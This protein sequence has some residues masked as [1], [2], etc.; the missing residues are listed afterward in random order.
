MARNLQSYFLIAAAIVLSGCAVGPNYKRP[1][2]PAS[3]TFKEPPPPG[4]KQAQ[5][6]AAIPR[7]KWWEIYND[8]QLNA[9][10]E[11]VAINNQNV[12]AAAARYREARDQVRIARSAYFPTIT[13]SPG[14]SASH[15]SDTLRRSNVSNLVNGTVVDYTLPVNFSYQADLWGSIRRS[16]RANRELAQASAADLENAKLSFQAQL[17]EFYFEL[18]GLDAEAQLL[19]TTVKIFQ[20]FLQLTKDRVEAGIASGADVAQAQTQLETTRAQL[21]DIGVQRASFEHALA[22]LIGKPPAELTLAFA[23]LQSV[24]PP[25]P[26]GVPSALLERRPDIASAERQVAAAN[27]QIGIAMA[28]YFPNLTL[29]AQGGLES[30]SFGQWLTWPSRFWSAGP[31]LAEV[32]FNGGK[33]SA[34]IDQQRA[35]YD[36]TAANY[37]QTVLTAFQQVEDNLAALRILEQEAAAQQQAVSAAEES[38]RIITEQYKAGTTDYL[39]VITTQS[40]ALQNERTALQIATRRMTASALLVE[41]LG[42]GWDSSQLPH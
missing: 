20:D 8:P 9:L 23:P 2:A 22:V 10:E 11:Q 13:A 37:R 24:P 7:G 16:V 36:L 40:I 18:R 4:W 21:I 28:A 15:S 34:T 29:S 3:A 5:P 14:V 1:A 31:Q 33:R 25:V 38:L 35:A 27:E 30:T 26:E 32:I 41:A 39:H 17:A 42:G 19:Q 12:M 6:N